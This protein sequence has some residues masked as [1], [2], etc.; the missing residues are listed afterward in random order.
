MDRDIFQMVKI[1][2]FTQVLGVSPA[3]FTQ[4]LHQYSV[5]GMIQNFN[6]QEKVKL[7]SAML[8]LADMI[9]TEAEKL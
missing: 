9:K 5:R 6:E 7:K 3:R 2:P 1:K 4:K 8:M